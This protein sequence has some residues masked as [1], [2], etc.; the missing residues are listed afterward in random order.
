MDQDKEKW[1]FLDE[2]V[3]KLGGNLS[4]GQKKIIHLL[5]I[6]LNDFTKIIILDEPSNGLD[7]TTRNNIVSYIQYLNSKNK[8]ILLITHDPYFKTISDKVLEFKPNE[9]PTYIK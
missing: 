2:T 3:G 4:G 6:E 8:M 1:S 5:R 9:N 7:E